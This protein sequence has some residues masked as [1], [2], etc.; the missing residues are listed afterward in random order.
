MLQIEVRLSDGTLLNGQVDAC[1][2]HYNLALI[3]IQHEVMVQPASLRILDDSISTHPCGIHDKGVGSESFQLRPHSDLIRL[4]PGDVVVA[5]GRYFE[6]PY[7][8][9]AA[10][11]R[12][13]YTKMLTCN[14]FINWENT[15]HTL[16]S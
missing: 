10:P 4:C 3:K 13:R 2:F 1:D 16:K 11:G 12:F 7:E 9:M 15:P 8:I 14:F 5:L 6:E